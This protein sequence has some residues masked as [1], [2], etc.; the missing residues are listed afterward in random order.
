MGYFAHLISFLI[1]YYKYG[2]TNKIIIWRTTIQNQEIINEFLLKNYE[3]RKQI[4]E[5]DEAL[6]ELNKT[7]YHDACKFFR[8]SFGEEDGEEMLHITLFGKPFPF[9]EF[10]GTVKG[11]VYNLQRNALDEEI[12]IVEEETN[13]Y[14]FGEDN[15]KFDTHVGIVCHFNEKEILDNVEALKSLVSDEICIPSIRQLPLNEA[16]S[17]FIEVFDSLVYKEYELDNLSDKE[18]RFNERYYGLISELKDKYCT[19]EE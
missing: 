13:F 8:E 9:E 18:K 4:T 1:I 11:Y 7:F 2:N 6:Q 5:L 14:R 19:E 12:E 15:Y 3:L 16:A 17:K 10:R